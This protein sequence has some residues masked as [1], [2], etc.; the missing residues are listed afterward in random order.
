MIFSISNAFERKRKELY[1]ILHSD[2]SF[3]SEDTL[4]HSK[5]LD[6][7]VNLYQNQKRSELHLAEN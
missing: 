3:I 4:Y 7:F 2:T 1:K 6:H 5:Q